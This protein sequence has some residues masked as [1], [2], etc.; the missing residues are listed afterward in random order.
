[1]LG[2]P[3]VLLILRELMAGVHRFDEL[4][5]NTGAADN[6]LT[7]RL[8]AMI[9]SGLIVRDAYRGGSRPRYDYLLT[10]A[11]ADA[12]PVLHAYALWAERHAPGSAPAPF[13]LLGRSCD[14]ESLSCES[15]SE[16]GERLTVDS[17]AWVR[18]GKVEREPTALVGPAASA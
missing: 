9:D 13:R 5:A 18:P 14:R 17:V 12:L 10:E 11:G 1:M 6:I 8:N 15:C 2:D 3:W 4:R 16:C 7:K